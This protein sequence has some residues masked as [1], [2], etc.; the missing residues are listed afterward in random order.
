MEGGEAEELRCC[1]IEDVRTAWSKVVPHWSSF[2][3][4]GHDIHRERIHGRALLNACGN[5]RGL[6]ALDIGCGEGWCSRQLADQGAIVSAVDVCDTM[7][8]A[9]RAFPNQTGRPVEY[10]VMDATEVDRHVWPNAFDLVT[11]C[12]SLHSMPDPASALRAARR[13]MA[14]TGR[15]V[16][17]IPHPITHM[18]G[19]RNAGR[20]PKNGLYLQAGKYFRS[21]PYRVW[22]H[23]GPDENGEAWSTIRWSR[24][25][26]EYTGM[27][28]RA[29]FV[30]T[31]ELE[32]RPSEADMAKFDRLR[33]AGQVPYY[34]I[35]VAEPASAPPPLD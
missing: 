30:I 19:G 18:L 8:G 24:P 32:P 27:L 4:D 16:C 22:W 3:R 2:V 34:L 25:L 15:L 9:A 14:P 28:K 5:V 35:L 13:V 12:M 21:A 26:S 6:H 11:A 33:N 31:T 23:A 17:S 29:G 7:I 10:L 1:T 20:Q